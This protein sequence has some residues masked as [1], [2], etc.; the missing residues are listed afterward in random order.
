MV[1]KY[2]FSSKQK[3][4]EKFSHFLEDIWPSVYGVI[5]ALFYGIINFIK[6]LISG[7]WPGK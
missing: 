3:F 6:F 1:D 7:L 2:Y 4:Q 5:N